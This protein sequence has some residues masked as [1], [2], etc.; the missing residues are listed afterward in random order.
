VA[1]VGD[2]GQPAPV[3][4]ASAKLQPLEPPVGVGVAL[5][6]AESIRGRSIV[7]DFC[8]QTV[9]GAP[10]SVKT[11]A[12]TTARFAVHVQGRG[13]PTSASLARNNT[14]TAEIAGGTQQEGTGC[15]SP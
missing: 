3:T 6:R 8:R 15:P 5:P 10:S 12:T 2:G 1:L 14:G 13:A 11:A 4:A 7:T 9:R